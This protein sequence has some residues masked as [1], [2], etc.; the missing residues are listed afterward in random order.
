MKPGLLLASLLS[1]L[2]LAACSSGGSGSRAPGVSTA[3]VAGSGTPTGIW[4][5]LKERPLR[6]PNLARG[7]ACPKTPGEQISPAFGPALGTGPIYPVGLGT[8][9]VLFF[10]YPPDPRSGFAGSDWGGEKVLWVSSPAYQGPAL[11]RGH[12]IDGPNGLRFE[13]GINPPEE[14]R[15]PEEGGTVAEEPGWRHWPSYTRL[16]APGCY[17][18]QV[19]GLDFS[20]TIV[21]EAVVA[22]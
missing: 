10:N 9:G 18:Y 8:D 14:L 5:T 19:D 1:A 4:E 11:I 16:R 21:F 13:E 15:L 7:G 2:F 17:A 22:D 3:P 20:Y 12:Q 6:L